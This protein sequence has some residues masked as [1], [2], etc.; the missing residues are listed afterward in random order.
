LDDLVTS[1][2]V[3]AAACSTVRRAADS[4]GVVKRAIVFFAVWWQELSVWQIRGAEMV[5]SWHG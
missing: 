2:A 5:L 3:W 4:G 1:L